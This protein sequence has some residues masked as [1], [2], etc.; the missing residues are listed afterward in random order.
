MPPRKG[1]IVNKENMLALREAYT[2]VYNELVKP[3]RV[4]VATQYFRL[5]WVPFLGHSLAWLIIA[6]R[7]HCYYNRQTQ[8]MRDWCTVTQEELARE[9]GVS[10]RTVRRLLQSEYAGLFIQEIKQEFRYDAKLGKRL[11]KPTRYRI[12]MDDPLIPEDQEKLEKALADQARKFGITPSQLQEIL[13]PSSKEDTIC[14]QPDK[15]SAWSSHQQDKMS[16]EPGHQQDKMSAEPG[17]QQ[18]KMSAWSGYQQ[19]K[20]SALLYGR[21]NIRNN[22]S[23]SLLPATTTKG[24]D[25]EEMAAIWKRW[26]ELS[27]AEQEPSPKEMHLL[28]ELLA[29][30]YTAAQILQAMEKAFRLFQ[31]K[32]EGDHIQSFAYC[33]PIV[34]EEKP[35]GEAE[36]IAE[37]ETLAEIRRLWQEVNH[38]EPNTIELE[39]LEQIAHRAE[40]AACASPCPDYPAA[41]GAGWVI[42]AI[43]DAIRAGSEFI[44]VRRVEIIVE[45]WC[46]EGPPWQK[47]GQQLLPSR[48]GEVVDTPI[49]T[50]SGPMPAH[51]LWQEALERLALQMTKAT[52]DTWLRDTCPISCEDNT[53]VIGVKSPYAKEWLENRL[54]G[55]VQRTVREI[56][57]R[58]MEISFVAG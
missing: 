13:K 7:Q 14:H 58:D 22:I 6:L 44:A 53:L 3:D 49:D 55:I 21:Q 47:M 46:E 36:G 28:R 26:C 56:L 24:A 23:T 37:T 33:V 43:R 45:R 19:D 39:E 41:G 34:R 35:A 8:E 9:I 31:P 16:A 5:K 17:H 50:P 4:F 51:Q 20:M 40:E 29:E 54:L 18:D 10:P 2:N 42:A 11:R 27:G 1:T 12:R 38:R 57:G 30:G 32:F 25:G 52:F 48:R 15:M